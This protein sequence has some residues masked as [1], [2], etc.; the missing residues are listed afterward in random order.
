M[1]GSV[2]D[3]KLVRYKRGFNISEARGQ[4]VMRNW[5][6]TSGVSIY[7]SLFHLDFFLLTQRASLARIF[8]GLIC[9]EFVT[10]NFV[11]SGVHC[12]VK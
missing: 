10:S 12:I 7:P 2:G 3:E 9:L 8:Y 1:S 4:L 5:F 6:D 11:I